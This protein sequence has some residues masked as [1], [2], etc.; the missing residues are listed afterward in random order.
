MEPE[1]YQQHV[2]GELMDY[3]A[4]AAASKD[5]DAAWRKF[6]ADRDVSVTVAGGSGLGA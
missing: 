4:A 2:L 3:I 6:W 5:V 1:N